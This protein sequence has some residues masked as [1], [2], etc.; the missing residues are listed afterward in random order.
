VKRGRWCNLKL[1]ADFDHFGKIAPS[2]I[3]LFAHR[4]P[5]TELSVMVLQRLQ[6]VCP[7][8]YVLSRMEMRALA[9]HDASPQLIPEFHCPQCGTEL[10]MRRFAMWCRIVVAV[11]MIVGLLFLPWFIPNPRPWKFFT[12]WGVLFG[13]IYIASWFSRYFCPVER[14][15]STP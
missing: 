5:A 1:I 15:G 6:A 14:V 7:C 4:V 9:T 13:L 8:G 10:R 11:P 2:L 12:I 3:D